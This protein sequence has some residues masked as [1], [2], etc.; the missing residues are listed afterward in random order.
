MNTEKAISDSAAY[1]GKESISITNE[2][3]IEFIDTLQGLVVRL[4]TIES[5]E[6]KGEFSIRDKF[7]ELQYCYNE[8]KPIQKALSND[9]GYNERTFLRQFNDSILRRA[10]QLVN[11]FT[12]VTNYY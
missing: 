2:Q 8:L 3:E 4:D 10:N 9:Y 6:A 1:V 11:K 7:N 5:K 12:G